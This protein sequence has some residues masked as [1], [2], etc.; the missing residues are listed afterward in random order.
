MWFWCFNWEEKRTNTNEVKTKI[1][2]TNKSESNVDTGEL[3]LV[4]LE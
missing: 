2:W 4:V 3:V 1:K